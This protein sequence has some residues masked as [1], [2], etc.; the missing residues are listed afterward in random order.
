MMHRVEN[1]MKHKYVK[2]YR[3]TAEK[4]G[5]IKRNK[6]IKLTAGDR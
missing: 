1:F 5:N 4:Q 2:T 3:K 6:A